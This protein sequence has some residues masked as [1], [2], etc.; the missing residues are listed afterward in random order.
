MKSFIIFSDFQQL[1]L[2]NWQDWNPVHIAFSNYLADE[3]VAQ[4]SKKF[5][6]INIT[7]H[8]FVVLDI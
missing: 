7:S 4:E 8:S 3:R 6:F 1:H 5:V 2:K